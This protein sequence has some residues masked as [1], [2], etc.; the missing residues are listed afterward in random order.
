MQKLTRQ[1]LYDPARYAQLRPGL[2]AR[3]MEHK[4]HRRLP[5]GPCLV[6]HFENRLTVQY[7]IQELVRVAHMTEP[8]GLDEELATYNP[9]I[10]DGTNW[11]ATLMIECEHAWWRHRGIANGIWI[12]VEGSRRLYAVADED[13][14]PAASDEGLV[15]FL[16]FELTGPLRSRVLA[17][18]GLSI[19]VDH[20]DYRYRVAPLPADLHEALIEDLVQP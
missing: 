8:A 13:L 17:G 19:G 18:A 15:H 14:G 4:R 11:K 6:L 1:D 12:G 16:R 2:R 7:Q 5:L 9:L 20:A 3:A 10:P